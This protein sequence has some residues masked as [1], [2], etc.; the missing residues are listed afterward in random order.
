[1]GINHHMC[2]DEKSC[3]PSVRGL[4][5]KSLGGFVLEK[6]MR[7]G[8]KK[9]RFPPWTGTLMGWYGTHGMNVTHRPI[10]DGMYPWSPV[11]VGW[12]P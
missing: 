12:Y 9:E 3:K 5:G 11:T 1:M 4:G 6:D 8:R 10:M 2:I 7:R